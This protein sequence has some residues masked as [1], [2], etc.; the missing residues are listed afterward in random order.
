[1]TLAYVFYLPPYPFSLFLVIKYE[2]AE[3]INEANIK[4]LYYP[5]G[6]LKNYFITYKSKI[7]LSLLRMCFSYS[8]LGKVLN[9]NPS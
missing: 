6:P 1:M 7:K 4:I 2:L 5:E 9:Q 3:N 8:K